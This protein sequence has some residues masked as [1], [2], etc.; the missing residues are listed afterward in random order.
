MRKL[1]SL[2]AGL[3]ETIAGICVPTDKGYQL[4]RG[5][6]TVWADHLLQGLDEKDHLLAGEDKT[7]IQLVGRWKSDALFTY[8]HST[9]LPLVKNH[10]PHMLKYGS[11]TT[12]KAAISL[13][14]A[15]SILDE[16]FLHDDG[17]Q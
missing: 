4:R 16:H 6:A 3:F 14:T 7:V 9:A 15:T 13:P 1:T 5:K 10:A 11:F 8:L 2:G 17:P 12:M